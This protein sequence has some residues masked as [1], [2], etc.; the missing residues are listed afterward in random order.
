L[1]EFSSPVEA[2]RWAVE[3]QHGMIERNAEI[4]D[5]KR[6]DFRIG[7]NLGD[8]IVDE[9]DLYG[10][11]VNIAARLETLAEPGGICVSR[12]VREQTR[13]RLALPFADGGEQSVK[14]I[15]RPIRIFSLSA[16]AVATLPRAAAPAVP[17]SI[18]PR[19]RARNIA[20]VAAAVVMLTVAGAV[21]RRWPSPKVPSGTI[22]AELPDKASRAAAPLADQRLSIV[23]LPFNNLSNDPDQQYFADGITEDLTTDLS[24]IAN[25]FVISRNTAFT[26]KDK[27]VN[28]KQIGQE[29]GVRYVLEGSVQRSGKQVRVNAQL[30]DAETDTH[31]WAERFDRDIGDLFALQSEITGRIATALNFALVDAEA[32]R[33]TA[34]P[35]ALDY[36]FRAS[37]VL[38][39]PPSLDNYATAI[40]QLEHALALDPQSIRARLLLALALSSSVLDGIS[41][42]SSADLARAE[43]LARQALAISPDSV[44]GHTVRGNLLRA[45]QRFHDAIPEYEA[46]IASDRNSAGSYANLGQCKLY[47]GS[48]DEVI[49]LV[50]QAIRLSPRSPNRGY[51]YFM[52][53]L[54]YL[55]QSHTDEAIA[56]FEKGRSASPAHPGPHLGLAAAYG[57]K[58]ETARAAA[59]LAEGRKR[60]G[61]SD[62]LSSIARL[63]ASRSFM[64]PKVRALFE[65]TVDVGMRNAGMPDE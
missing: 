2:V 40:D 15:A 16:A 27:P 61:N 8:V 38:S 21:W 25:S 50:E 60:V 18:K 42:T 51:W 9:K 41:K 6:I 20:I 4:P 11:A 65:A 19:Y 23:V 55:L 1:I 47:T 58:G 31:I 63:D 28:A 36:I 29:L 14:N 22:T 48:V 56:E 24:R 10:D 52:I 5:D 34:N 17:L 3:M 49:P 13:D 35:D 39:K 43:E 53:G 30:I 12:A 26:Y 45:Q 32:A 44:L 7:I 59:E 37:A 33:P 57:L 64:A 46:V 54:T 62:F